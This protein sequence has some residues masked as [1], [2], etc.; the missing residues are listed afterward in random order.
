VSARWTC[1]CLLLAS[2]AA[3]SDRVEQAKPLDI[4]KETVCS[5]DGMTLADYPGP[6]GQIHYDQGPPD[7]FCDTKEVLSMLLRPEQRKRV[8]GVFVQ[9]MGKADWDHPSGNWIDAKTATYVFGSRRQGSMGP[10]VATFAREDDALQFVRQYGGKVL[11]FQEITPDMV[12]LDG[13]V[14]RDQRM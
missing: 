12:S 9:D 6:K 8:T 5:L 4:T 10:T 7:F 1:I 13:G 2:I 14:L 3:C 11:H